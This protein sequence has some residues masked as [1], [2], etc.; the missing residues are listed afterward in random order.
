MRWWRFGGHKRGSDKRPYP[1]RRLF[2]ETLRHPIKVIAPSDDHEEDRG[3]CVMLSIPVTNDLS[4]MTAEFQQLMRPIVEERIRELG[5]P[6]SKPMFEVTSANPSLKSL[7]KMLMA[8]RLK[9]QDPALKRYDLAEKLGITAKIEGERGDAHHD[10]AVYSVLSRLL[11]KAEVLIRNVELGR[12]PDHTDYQ[13]NGLSPELPRALR[14]RPTK[15]T[16]RLI[17]VAGEEVLSLF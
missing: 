6:I 1:G 15:R 17:A 2:S 14:P 12:F 4:R 10:A 8:W 11:K 13:K 3:E 9:E 7:H 16:E 5:E